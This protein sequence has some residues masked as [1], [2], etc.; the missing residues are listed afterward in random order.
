MKKF[1]II[2][3][4]IASMM[5]SFRNQLNAKEMKEVNHKISIFPLGNKL[6]EMYSK[7]FT[8]QAYLASLTQNKDLKCPISNVTF[9]PGCR[10][11]WHSHSGGQIL[12]VISGRG[13]YQVKG[14]PARLLIPGDVL[15][16]PANEVHWH[17]ASPDSWFSHLAIE[18]NPEDSKTTWLEAVDDKQY[19]EATTVLES[20]VPF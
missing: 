9:E 20:D 13:Y 17:G 8:G 18:T 4:S 5:L 1:I 12:V 6:P 14:E 19:K 7:Y 16:I 15:E 3:I 11:N 10:N 2:L